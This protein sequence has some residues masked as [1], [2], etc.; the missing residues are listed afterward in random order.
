MAVKAINSE[1]DIEKLLESGWVFSI[2][3]KDDEEY[4]N[5]AFFRHIE[6]DEIFRYGNGWFV[7]KSEKLFN[8]LVSIGMPKDSQAYDSCILMI[9]SKHAND[10]SINLLSLK[11][12]K[13]IEKVSKSIIEDARKI[14]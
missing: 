1:K 13:N 10:I 12:G 8:G 6:K 7:K 9:M 14:R 2:V 3:H 11:E 4:F 5:D